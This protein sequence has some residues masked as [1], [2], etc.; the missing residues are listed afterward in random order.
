MPE[1]RRI[2]FEIAEPITRVVSRKTTFTFEQSKPGARQ[3]ISRHSND[4]HQF[5]KEPSRWESQGARRQSGQPAVKPT[6]SPGRNEMTPPV[7]R[8]GPEE[9]LPPERTESAPVQ[10][11]RRLDAPGSARD[12]ATMSPEQQPP[13]AV[14]RVKA[15]R[16]DR[17]R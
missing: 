4:V 14:T 6:P 8:K 10:P 9:T 11:G 1:S 7:K 3:Q 2:N 16:I 12:G 15:N 17:A 13:T 5:V